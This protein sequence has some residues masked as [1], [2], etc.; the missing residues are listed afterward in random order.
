MEFQH[1]DT[2]TEGTQTELVA[3]GDFPTDRL[4][5][6]ELRQLLK[7]A[8]T[9]QHV[10]NSLKSLDTLLSQLGIGPPHR[11]YLH[12]LSFPQ[13]IRTRACLE[14][15]RRRTRDVEEVIRR[16]ESEELAARRARWNPLLKSEEASAE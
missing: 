1:T 2:P 4:T 12:A 5:D 15:I 16:R 3:V 14:L 9:T 11:H 13:S 7:G 10:R 8:G 6:S